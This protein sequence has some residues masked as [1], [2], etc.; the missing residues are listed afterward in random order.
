MVSDDKHR[1]TYW[2]AITIDCLE[3]ER[4][5]QFWGQLL[6]TPARAIDLPGW[7]RLG[8]IVSGGPVITFQPVVEPKTG[9]T[10]IHIDL[11]SD[12]LARSVK[13]IEQLGGNATGEI[14]RY[15]EGTVMVMTDPEGNE[16]CLVGPAQGQT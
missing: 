4:V 14:H 16:F 3:P 1:R 9:K 12:D 15:Q 10:R 8:P 2:A 5:S 13:L 7:F 11:W 6:E